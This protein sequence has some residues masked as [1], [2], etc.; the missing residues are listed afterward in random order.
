MA[1]KGKIFGTKIFRKTGKL[2]IRAFA[3]RSSSY[4]AIRI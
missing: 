3:N 2:F 1:T 4:Q